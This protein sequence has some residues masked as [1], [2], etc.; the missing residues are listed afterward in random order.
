MSQSEFIDIY[1][2]SI[3]GSSHGS[4]LHISTREPDGLVVLGIISHASVIRP[5]T[6]G[7]AQ[8]LIQWLEQHMA[9]FP[10]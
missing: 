5:K 2:R 1:Q 3:S 6:R 10:V 7:D 8:K 4:S 9:E